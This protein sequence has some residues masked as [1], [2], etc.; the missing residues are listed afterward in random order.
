ML[1][2]LALAL[3]L[4]CATPGVELT[5]GSVDAIAHH[6]AV[7][8][9]AAYSFG[10]TLCN[11]G[12]AP[13]PWVANAAAHP[14][15]GLN[16]YR[17]EGGRLEQLGMSWL[18]H[19]TIPLAQAA[20]CPCTPAGT[21]ALGPGCSDA[22]SAGASGAQSQLGPRSEVDPAGASYAYPFGTQGQGGDALHKRLQVAIDDLDLALHP[23]AR[24]LVEA[25]VVEPGDDVRG[26]ADA[27]WR[28]V[29]PTGASAAGAPV[30]RLEGPS[31]AQASAL[32]AWASL[33][34]TVVVRRTE[35][36]ADGEV[37]CAASVRDL[38]GGAWE[39]VYAVRNAT[40]RRAVGGLRVPLGPAAVAS[41]GW[42]APLWH[43]GEPYGN[44]PWTAAVAA[45]EATWRTT[46]FSQDPLAS[47]V[48]FGTTTTFRLVA[49]RAPELRTVTLE[50]FE[51]GGP[52][53]VSVV[54]PAPGGSGAGVVV[55]CAG[56]PNSTGAAGELLPSDVDPLART[57]ALQ[58]GALPPA[59]FGMVVTSLTPD[60]VV[61]PGG[62]DGN[63]CLGG[64]IGRLVGGVVF[65]SDALGRA[66]VAVDLD[67][68]P[69]PVGFVAVQPGETRYF[70]GWYRDLVPA[71][72]TS[73]F[74]GAVGLTFP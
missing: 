31:T 52:P 34:P 17:V 68:V 54:L 36:P 64:A 26:A 44:A 40:S 70:Q 13:A 60:F 62:S 27:G 48:R 10:T 71:G 49:D 29:V 66:T 33:D 19:R 28:E 18:Q 6:G 23:G 51:P 12:D 73:N 65:Q 4:P 2:L 16:L 58:I 37:Q 8:P 35:V 1:P 43:S 56:V 72:V 3:Q 14:L 5:V 41:Q 74:T 24:F 47:A 22:S 7:G 57:M 53:E 39:Y 20:C 32:D 11:L 38:G 61:G 69:T 45:G 55:T 63:L 50:L 25:F 9:L 46:A 30:L 59:R 15:V 21:P 67:H 42:S